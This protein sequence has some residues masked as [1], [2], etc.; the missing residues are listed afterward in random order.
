MTLP[1]ALE[2]SYARRER[3]RPFSEPDSSKP[4]QNQEEV[5]S[6]TEPLKNST[7]RSV[8]RSGDVPLVPSGFK[9]V[10]GDFTALVY[11][12]EKC[13]FMRHCRNQDCIVRSCK[14]SVKSWPFDCG[15]FYKSG[16]WVYA[17]YN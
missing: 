6:Q 3:A 12:G 5:W 10:Q 13:G 17:E 1:D 14:W 11:F 2:S 8:R 15:L 9:N 16:D 7:E 4:L